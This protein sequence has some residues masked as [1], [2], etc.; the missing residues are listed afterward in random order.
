MLGSGVAYGLTLYSLHTIP[1]NEWPAFKTPMYWLSVGLRFCFAVVII[2]L[3]IYVIQTELHG[4]VAFHLGA[5]APSILSGLV[6][7]QPKIDVAADA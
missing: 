7:T 2:V 1:R 6:K 5:S 4:L 3:Y